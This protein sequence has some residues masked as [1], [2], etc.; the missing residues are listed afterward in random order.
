[1]GI[2][3]NTH[4]EQSKTRLTIDQ[5][6]GHW[7]DAIRP[8]T[9][10]WLHEHKAYQ[11]HHASD[12]VQ[13]FV[14]ALKKHIGLSDMLTPNQDTKIHH[15]SY[16]YLIDWLR[17]WTRC[18]LLV[19]ES[20]TIVPHRDLEKALSIR[21]SQYIAMVQYRKSEGPSVLTTPNSMS[22]A[23]LKRASYSQYFYE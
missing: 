15:A 11:I 10:R 17:I 20:D 5:N 2:R 9:F 21:R 13:Q 1:M 8:F 14:I 23:S 4:S 22:K 3:G 12:H 19:Q 16:E 7:P 6:D 18:G